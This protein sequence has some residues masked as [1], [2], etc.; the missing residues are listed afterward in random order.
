MGSPFCTK[1]QEFIG[2]F[3]RLISWIFKKIISWELSP[4]LSVMGT[5][6]DLQLPLKNNFGSLVKLVFS[7]NSADTQWQSFGFPR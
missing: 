3:L 7:T 1:V 4:N 6:Q 2:I 5:E